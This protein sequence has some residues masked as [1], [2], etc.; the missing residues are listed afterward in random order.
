MVWTSSLLDPCDHSVKDRSEYPRVES[1]AGERVAGWCACGLGEE[2]RDLE[3]CPAT[4][5]SQS[6]VSVGSFGTTDMQSSYRRQDY[7]GRPG[8]TVNCWESTTMTGNPGGKG[9]LTDPNPV[10]PTG[11]GIAHP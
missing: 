5:A 6:N 9:E 10:R 1:P 2:S 11:T 4:F 3:A 7:A 8:T